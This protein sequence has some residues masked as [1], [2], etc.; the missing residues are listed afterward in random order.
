MT[1]GHIHYIASANKESVIE[2]LRGYCSPQGFALEALAPDRP[3]QAKY[4][5][6]VEPV[7]IGADGYALSPIWKSWLL[8]NSPD[9][10]LIIASYAQSAHKNAMHLLH[11]P[12]SLRDWL[13]QVPPVK[14]YLLQRGVGESQGEKKVTYYDPWDWFLPM[15]G[16]DMKKQMIKFLE[17][18]DKVNSFTNQVG[19]LRKNLMDIRDIME[20]DLPEA[21]KTELLPHTVEYRQQ[22]KEDWDALLGRWNYYKPFFDHLPF[23]EAAREIEAVIETLKADSKSWSDPAVI[24]EYDKIDA[25]KQLIKARLDRFIFMEDYW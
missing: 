19:R 23:Q 11:L 10:R 4:L 16:R 15:S 20:A 2:V 14:A 13:E 21:Y 18:H 8:E 1:H 12:D 24:P 25:L 7:A 5:M 3:F 9:T 6:I 17:G 22:A